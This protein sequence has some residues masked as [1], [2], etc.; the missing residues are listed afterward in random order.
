[1]KFLLAEHGTTTSVYIA[2]ADVVGKYHFLAVMMY[3]ENI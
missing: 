3:V 1:M 2:R